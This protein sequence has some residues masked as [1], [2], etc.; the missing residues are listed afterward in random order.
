[1]RTIQQVADALRTM[2][3]VQPEQNRTYSLPPAALPKLPPAG[4]ARVQIAQSHNHRVWF[5][6]RPGARCQNCGGLGNV[7]MTFAIAGPM[8]TPPPKGVLKW[9]DGY[10]VVESAA[11]PCPVCS[12][13][14]AMIL[15]YWSK[16]G[17][18]SEER[19]WRVDTYA[20]ETGKEAA[21]TAAQAMMGTAPYPSGWLV[22]HGSY[23][24]GKSG[25][26]KALTA[27]MIRAGVSAQYTR[28]E[29]VLDDIR[30]TYGD[31]QEADTEAVRNHYAGVQFLAM[32]EVDRISDTA[33][34]RAM[35]AAIVDE[36]HR[37]MSSVCTVFATNADPIDMPG[38]EYLASRF[39]DGARVLMGGRDLRGGR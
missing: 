8:H 34:A 4:V 12:D 13:R 29:Q 9:D 38:L 25:I 17:L 16:S 32:D 3:A 36:R 22:L 10:W 37:M 21:V 30:A 5:Y 20:K 18:T 11:Y 35:L 31:D 24:V 33:W 27:A 1:M 28:A 19:A 39:K 7:L 23:G 15:Y 26:L 6:S 2:P 14:E